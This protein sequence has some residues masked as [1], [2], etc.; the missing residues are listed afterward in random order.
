MNPNALQ[1]SEMHYPQV[2][3][4]LASAKRSVAII[5]AGSVEAHG[6]H[7]PLSTDT[8]ISDA[9]A[10]RA[11]LSLAEADWLAIVFPPVHY[12]VTDWAASFSGTT[13]IPA[14]VTHGL[15]M[16]AAQAARTMG[17]TRIAITNAHLEP[18]H[19]A[20]LRKVAK[21]FETATGEPLVFADK[22]RR[23]NAERLTEEFR[24]GS[25]HAGQYET[26]LML[27]IRPDLVQQTLAEQLPEHYVALH[28]KIAAGAEDF[29]QCG[30]DNA[31]CGAPAGAT[32]A[33]G[34]RSLEI[35]ADMVVQAVQ[36]SVT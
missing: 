12:G 21:D 7:L 27:A 6:P 26:S 28:E 15:F 35:L 23:K 24:S 4:L 33:E 20:T 10:R 31:Y 18:G 19:I 13:S 30:L 2:Q 5:P 8:M 32:A 14:E 1:L 16:A 17:F 11:A 29:A 36:D 25:C 22:T 34:E 9:V 3:S